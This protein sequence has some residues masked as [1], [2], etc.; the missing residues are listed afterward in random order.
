VNANSQH[1]FPKSALT[2]PFVLP[3]SQVA[4]QDAVLTFR[5]FLQ[6]GRSDVH[7]SRRMVTPS[8]EEETAEWLQSN[9]YP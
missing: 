6:G 1:E 8:Q 7:E 3:L 4:A 5:D 9:W 2:S